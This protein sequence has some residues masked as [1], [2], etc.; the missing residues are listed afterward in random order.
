MDPVGRIPS[1]D[2][3]SPKTPLLSSDSSFFH[4]LHYHLLNFISELGFGEEEEQ[5]VY[6][7][8]MRG[9]FLFNRPELY[10][11]VI[12]LMLII[13]SFYLALWVVNFTYSADKL[14]QPDGYRF[15]SLLP[16]LL[17]S[18]LMVYNVRSSYL[19]KVRIEY[20]KITTLFV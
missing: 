19:L 20:L 15:L 4:R 17:C 10:Y 13:I 18:G 1:K 6:T 5:G 3:S 7:D 16:G 14:E 2:K 12:D 11:N 8:E 9:V